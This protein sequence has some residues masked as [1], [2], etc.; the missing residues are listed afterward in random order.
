MLSLKGH[1]YN[2]FEFAYLDICRAWMPDGVDARLE[3]TG[4]LITAIFTGMLQIIIFI[5]LCIYNVPSDYTDLSSLADTISAPREDLVP[6][7]IV[8]VGTSL[9]FTKRAYMQFTESRDFNRALQV[10]TRDWQTRRLFIRQDTYGNQIMLVL[11]MLVN[12]G[13]AS[14]IPFFNL[15]YLL[16][17]QTLDDAI[18]N[19]L[20]L[21]FILELDEVVLPGWDSDRIDDELADN[22]IGEIFHEFKPDDVLVARDGNSDF[23]AGDKLYT[24]VHYDHSV[25]I[26][27]TDPY[28]VWET[29]DDKENKKP[30]CKGYIIVYKRTSPTTYERTRYLIGGRKAE[31]F[32]KVA[33]Q[34]ECMK[35]FPAYNFEKWTCA[36]GCG[37]SFREMKETLDHEHVCPSYKSREPRDLQ[38]PLSFLQLYDPPTHKKHK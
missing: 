27:P 35:K 18:L 10:R 21:L 28:A 11:N 6:I 29:D 24:K 7:F 26:H 37:L 12:Q 30:P 5:L 34:F 33:S 38:G 15:W 4:Y 13:L 16:L 23:T 19:S 9:L 8:A 14:V 31:Q 3:S 32:L 22:F 36:G 25:D 17:S 2:I 20:A 1:G